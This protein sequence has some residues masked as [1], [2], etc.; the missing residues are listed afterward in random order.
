MIQGLKKYSQL[1][2]GK[3]IR[4]KFQTSPSAKLDF[5]VVGEKLRLEESSQGIS[6]RTLIGLMVLIL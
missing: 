5:R 6:W 2:I 3:D 4:V 1:Q